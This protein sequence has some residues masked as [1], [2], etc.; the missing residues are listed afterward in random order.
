MKAHRFLLLIPLLIAVSAVTT[1]TDYSAPAK[2]THSRSR[3]PN[4]LV[5]GNSDYKVARCVTGYYAH[6]MAYPSLKVWFEVITRKPFAERDED[7]YQGV[8]DSL[9]RVRSALLLAVRDPQ[10]NGRNYLIPVD[11]V[12]TSGTVPIA[13]VEEP[14]AGADEGARNR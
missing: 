2:R 1:R 3:A 13:S 7:Q 14:C 6:D 12:I 9:V 10:I 5:I 8:G 4:S 11:T